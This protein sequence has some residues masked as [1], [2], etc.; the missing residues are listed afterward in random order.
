MQS[1]H[2]LQVLGEN[3][4][5]NFHPSYLECDKN[6]KFTQGFFSS[7]QNPQGLLTQVIIPLLYTLNLIIHLVVT[8]PR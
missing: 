4:R 6:S 3:E 2:Q 7:I 1:S 5:E 8:A